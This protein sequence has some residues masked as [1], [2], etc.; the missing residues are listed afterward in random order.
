MIPDFP[1][2]IRIRLAQ[3][4]FCC[5]LTL[6][7]LCPVGCLSFEKLNWDSQQGRDIATSGRNKKINCA[8]LILIC[9]MRK[10][11]YHQIWIQTYLGFIV[12]DLMY[13]HTIYIVCIPKLGKLQKSQEPWKSMCSI[14]CHT[15]AKRSSLKP[16]IYFRITIRISDNES[17]KKIPFS[18][19]NSN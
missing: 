16:I 1:H 9:I 5:A 8:N 19:I 2:N 12:S 11:W 14:P 18:Y 7:C 6:L 4:I 10:V 15:K 13:I 3:L 17:I